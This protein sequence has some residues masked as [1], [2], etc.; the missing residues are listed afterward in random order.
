ML[1]ISKKIYFIFLTIA[2]FALN[3]QLF[4]QK[5]TVNTDL[6]FD[7]GITRDKN[8]NLWPVLKYQNEDF[9]RDLQIM[10]PIY[11]RQTD[12]VNQT[13][14]SHFIPFYWNSK[15]SLVQDKRI[16]SL[17]YPSLLRFKND[18]RTQTKSFRF[19]ELAPKINMLEFTKSQDGL[20]VKNNLLFFLWAKNDI[21]NQSSHLVC[22]PLYWSFAER[23]YRTNTFLPFYSYG[24]YN[25]LQSSYK[26]IT[27]LYWNFKTDDRKTNLL[28]PIYY[29]YKDSVRNNK[30]LAPLAWKFENERYKSFT[31]LP[32]F[33]KGVS[34]DLSKK[35]LVVSPLFWNMKSKAG[36]DLALLPVYYHKKRYY[37][38]DTAKFT[39][40][41]PLYW[42]YRSK[43]EN[44][45][46]IVPIYWSRQNPDYKSFTVFPIISKGAS[47]DGK[48]KHLM[49]TPLFW[50]FK[51]PHTTNKIF[52]PLVWKNME[53][54][55]KDTSTSL[56]IVPFYWKNKRYY[57]GNVYSSKTFFPVY[58]DEKVNNKITS[59]TIL[60]FYWARNNNRAK[61]RI[62]FP[63][64]WNFYNNDYHSFTFF[65]L[66][67]RGKSVDSTKKHLMIAELY[68]DFQNQ[69][70]RDKVFFPLAYQRQRYYDDDTTRLTSV[71]L[72]YWSYKSKEKTNRALAP[73]IWRIKNDKYKSFT[74]APFYSGGMAMDSSY[75]YHMIASLFWEFERPESKTKMFLPIYYDK[76]NYYSNDTTSF[77]ML[78]PL[79]YWYR[80]NFVKNTVFA[81][82]YWH[83]KN[84]E[85]ESKTLLPFYSKG[86]ATDSSRRY[87]MLGMLYWETKNKYVQEKFILPVYYGRNEV[88]EYGVSKFRT[89]FPVYWS[90]KDYE[91]D[92]KVIFP[93]I[94]KLKYPAYTSFTFFPFYS[95]GHSSNMEKKHFMLA[96][97][98]WRF[99][100][101]DSKSSTLFP[102]Y[103]NFKR[104]YRNDTVKTT[105]VLP[106]Y[107]S[108]KSN[109]RTENVLFPVYW[110]F[111]DESS[112]S[113]T[114]LPFYSHGQLE[115]GLKYTA[116]TPLF[117]NFKHEN[118]QRSMLFPI[119]SNYSNINGDK[120]NNLL[121]FLVRHKKEGTRNSFNLLWPI[122]ERTTDV[123]YSYFRF[124]PIIWNKKTKDS[125]FFSIQPF[126][127]YT[128]DTDSENHYIFWQLYT[129]TNQ[130]GY[131]KSRRFLWRVFYKD[132]YQNNDFETRFLYLVYANVN[133][134]GKKEKSL[135]PLFHKTEDLKGNRSF[136]LLFYFYNSFQRRIGDSNDFYK[137]EK[138]FWFLRLRSNY[139]QL[140]REGKIS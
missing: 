100:T 44:N 53:I 33:S 24:K 72:L 65:P 87:K 10:F 54:S 41:F 21:Q 90:Y 15:D 135:F 105:T 128:R 12:S 67:S 136:S 34:P 68:W 1:S 61:F 9:K 138:I 76:V 120:K 119:Y 77:K 99:E 59:R 46:T 57:R 86:S 73:L 7:F 14:K 45:K 103:W 97:L 37:Y 5:D 74:F 66:F 102:V 4:A 25:S 126:Y 2:V 107:W 118:Y 60:P 112:G 130:F 58:W 91:L 84:P 114:I 23:N 108:H 35:H 22:F 29:S 16:L 42:S 28:F 139:R 51:D 63:V 39:T 82:F 110:R 121:L 78:F 85:Y 36:S 111:K 117:W 92:N 104:Y 13:L 137:E 94:W 132:T 134:D 123:D 109:N 47:P 101:P 69:N 131:K 133:K 50:S 27:P 18:Q 113:T 17:Y 106:V 55:Y 71:A 3:S 81:P 89:V 62:L 49:L 125:R 52:F 56:A 140:K 129:T 124:A 122:C 83:F 115:S 95:K 40:I 32:L 88:D 64:A 8:I 6:K 38:N 26:A 31:L 98:F 93:L 96:T 48:E 80:D 19:L 75:K 11:R 70:G 30:I 43:Y 20:F 79:Y 127:T 116:I